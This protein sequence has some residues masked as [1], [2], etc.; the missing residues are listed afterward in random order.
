MKES[1]DSYKAPRNFFQIKG[2]RVPE[3]SELCSIRP[4]SPQVP[5]LWQTLQCSGLSASR[6]LAE[7]AG[8]QSHHATGT[9]MTERGRTLIPLD[10]LQIHSK[11]N[12]PGNLVEALSY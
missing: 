9:P 2:L 10:I 1:K 6:L 8:R 12:I 4:P 11:G 7:A 3:G 5:Q